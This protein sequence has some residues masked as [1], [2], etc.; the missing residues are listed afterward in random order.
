MKN[1]VSHLLRILITCSALSFFSINPAYAAKTVDAS[2]YNST[3]LEMHKAIIFS[4]LHYQ[5]K[6]K[7]QTSESYTLQYKKA[8]LG[9]KIEGQTIL[10]DPENEVENQKWLTR[11]KKLIERRLDYN[12]KV[13][14]AAELL[15]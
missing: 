5:W 4:A 12:S 6:I 13:R 1:K 8:N 3:A 7:E 11:L 15:N 10:I 14:K 2:S 9:I